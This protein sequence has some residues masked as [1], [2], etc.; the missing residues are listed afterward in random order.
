MGPLIDKLD[1]NSDKPYAFKLL[2]CPSL[3]KM[4]R[5]LIETM[6][7]LRKTR[8]SFKSKELVKL[9]DKLDTIVK[10]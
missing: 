6:E 5:G 2:E 3:T 7:V 4:K 8:E 1:S 9:R 10:V